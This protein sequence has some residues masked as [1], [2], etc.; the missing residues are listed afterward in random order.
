MAT[1]F[2]QDTAT[3]ALLVHLRP[4]FEMTDEQFEELCR[5]NRDLGIE[6]TAEGDLIIMPPTGGRTGRRNNLLAKALLRWEEQDPSGL[7]F[8]SSTGFT[9]PSGA[10]RSPDAS[11]VKRSRLAQLTE[12]EK[13]KFL[14]LCPDFVIELR[15]ASD[16]LADLQ[17][18]M[19]EYIEGGAE[20]GWLIDP[21]GK[22]VFVY[23]AD[24]SMEQLNDPEALTGDP[25]LKG[26]VLALK[27]IWEADF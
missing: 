15:S 21:Q 20:L 5:I 2:E 1:T 9:L 7:S 8:D 6:M 11:W 23:R 16:S 18:K 12:E 13:E 22:H 4:V 14:P 25:V 10:K 27:S 24:K 17:A 3:P 19:R 26:F